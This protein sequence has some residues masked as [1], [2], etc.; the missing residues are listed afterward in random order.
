MEA[1]RATHNNETEPVLL[2]RDVSKHE[3][4][5]SGMA[6]PSRFPIITRPFL[7][8]SHDFSLYQDANL[9]HLDNCCMSLNT[10]LRTRSRFYIWLHKDVSFRH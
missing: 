6:L 8:K 9:P 1:L 4:V 10:W 3:Q 2:R 7:T 5:Y